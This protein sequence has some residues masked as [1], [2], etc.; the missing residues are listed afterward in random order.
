MVQS[1]LWS[2]LLGFGRINWFDL[3]GLGW[4]D[5][6]G[7]FLF[8]GDNSDNSDN[9]DIFRVSRNAGWTGV[10]SE[11]RNPK[12]SGRQVAM[13]KGRPPSG[14]GDEHDDEGED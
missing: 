11:G 5:G 8:L 9:S 13:R 2:D 12:A 10:K 14:W 4:T 6:D 3:V 7:C 1:F